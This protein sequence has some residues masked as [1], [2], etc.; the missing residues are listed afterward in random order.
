MKL[1]SWLPQLSQLNSR[2]RASLA[3]V[4]V[5][6]QVNKT[7]TQAPSQSQPL[8]DCHHCGGK[9]LQRDCCFRLAECNY[10]KRIGHIAKVCYS[11]IR[12]QEKSK[13][14]GQQV[15]RTHQVTDDLTTSEDAYSLFH[16]PVSRSQPLRVSL[17]LNAVPMSTEITHQS[18]DISLIVCSVTTASP[19]H[20]DPAQDIHG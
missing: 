7:R 11:R 14:S 15:Q 2:L 6:S 3:P 4:H 8:S 9:H 12:D 17:S 20:P 19:H 1:S 10:L 18:E 16:L 5:V 13:T